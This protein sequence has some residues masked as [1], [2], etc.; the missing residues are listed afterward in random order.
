[1]KIKCVKCFIEFG[2]ISKLN[3]HVKKVHQTKEKSQICTKCGSTF[4]SVNKLFEHFKS[5]HYANVDLIEKNTE[6]AKDQHIKQEILEKKP[7]TIKL[8]KVEV[9]DSTLLA[10]KIKCQFCR[11]KYSINDSQNHVLE[12]E[13]IIAKNAQSGFHQATV[14]DYCEKT[15]K[16]GA[17]E[18]HFLQCH[19]LQP[20]LNLYKID[21]GFAKSENVSSG[22]NN[23]SGNQKCK[24][25]N[26]TFPWT[27][28]NAYIKNHIEKCKAY[29]SLMKDGQ[30]CKFCNEHQP[31]FK[32]IIKHIQ[33]K[34][35]KHTPGNKY[36]THCDKVFVI[37]NKSKV[38]NYV[39]NH[40]KRC[41]LYHSYVK[42]QRTCQLCS[43][44]FSTYGK[45]LLHIDHKH[46]RQ[47]NREKDSTFNCGF[48]QKAFEKDDTKLTIDNHVEKCKQVYPF[49]INEKTC[50]ICD[51]IFPS[52]W[53]VWGHIR[54]WHS[55]E[56]Q[57]HKI[58]PKVE[59]TNED[60]SMDVEDKLHAKS[61]INEQEMLD[62]GLNYHQNKKANT[63]E[64]EVDPKLFQPDLEQKINNDVID[65][66]GQLHDEEFKVE[67]IANL[68]SEPSKTKFNKQMSFTEKI[69][70]CPVC[71][72]NL[73]STFKNQLDSK[74]KDHILTFH[75]LSM[76][77]QD[78]YR[79]EPSMKFICTNCDYENIANKSCQECRDNLCD[80]CVQAHERTRLTKNHCLI[81]I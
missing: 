33:E 56:L 11:Q 19:R 29:S 73:H 39:E 47:I 67:Y 14:C 32:Q 34:H 76:T 51:K 23:S 21:V 16:S 15:F 68:K 53:I 41:Q 10:Q 50:K 75:H 36:C 69:F 7:I 25:C 6:D 40:L 64:G 55:N 20:F 27:Q 79:I 35:P 1:M 3:D 62:D 58:V 74:V 71:D 78:Q 61:G 81:P 46:S 12:C 17:R 8:K 66:D 49:I 72:P 5:H 13:S 26:K 77:I 70:V 42:D 57:E 44:S 43:K 37:K 65:D 80:Q 2:A 60:G 63:D 24:Y 45:V 22:K 31:N 18:S 48:C 4:K 28:I 9:E 52:H 54:K 38:D 30:K 59:N